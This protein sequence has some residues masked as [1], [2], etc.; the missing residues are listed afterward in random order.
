[1]HKVLQALLDTIQLAAGT[2][3][4]GSAPHSPTDNAQH[5]RQRIATKPSIDR[6]PMPTEQAEHSDPQSFVGEPALR[7]STEKSRP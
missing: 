4:L 7:I 1:M 3:E 6:K 2:V 5:M